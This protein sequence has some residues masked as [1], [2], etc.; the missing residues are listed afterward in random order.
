M[1]GGPNTPDV[2]SV[3]LDVCESRRE[4]SPKGS[5]PK[6]SEI[7]SL[8]VG[9]SD[10]PSRGHTNNRW[11]TLRLGDKGFFE[12]PKVKEILHLVSNLR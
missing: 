3:C 4:R 6:W 9:R 12:D 2:G 10:P 1:G 7:P 5:L 11:S 8:Q